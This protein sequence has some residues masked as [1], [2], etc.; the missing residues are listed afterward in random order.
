MKNKLYSTLLILL[1]I[2]L[3]VYSQKM[4]SKRFINKIHKEYVEKLELNDKQSTAFKNI[5]KKY[6]PEIKKL[7]DKKSKNTEINRMIKLSNSEI[8]QILTPIQLT[9]YNELKLKLEPLKKYRFGS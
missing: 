3:N 1:F 2:S 8:H 5:L 7:I 4:D 9:K 6:N